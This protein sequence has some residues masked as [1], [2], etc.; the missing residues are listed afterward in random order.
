MLLHLLKAK[1]FTVT[2]HKDIPSLI[3]DLDRLLAHADSPLPWSTPSEVASARSVLEEVRHYL[4]ERQHGEVEA[5]VRPNTEQSIARSAEQ[6]LNRLR[7]EWVDTLQADLVGLHQQRES[8]VRDIRQLESKRQHLTQPR[9]PLSQENAESSLTQI[10]AQLDVRLGRIESSVRGEG[11][12]SGRQ[13]T[14]RS[15][16]LDRLQ[17]RSDRQIVAL[18]ASQ[19]T[20]FATLQ[21]NLR[22]YEQS[23]SQGLERMHHLGV[24]GE[25]LVA[26]LV[27]RITQQLEQASV[28]SPEKEADTDAQPSPAGDEPT[29]TE[30]PTPS[31]EPALEVPDAD[32]EL[33]DGLDWDDSDFELDEDDGLDTFIQLDVGAP[34]ALP[35]VEEIEA[36][37]QSN[38]MLTQAESEATATQSEDFEGHHPE[39]QALYESLFG[40][41]ALSGTPVRDDAE[42]GSDRQPETFATHF[43]LEDDWSEAV[44]AE[45]PESESPE[46]LTQDEGNASASTS[47]LEASLFSGLSDPATE[48]METTQTPP[49]E[50]AQSWE[51]FLFEDPVTPPPA[52]TQRTPQGSHPLSTQNGVREREG[53]ETISAL[54]A[55]F[56]EMGLSEEVAAT[57]TGES[58]LQAEDVP[59][60]ESREDWSEDAYIYASPGEDLLAT[61]RLESVPEIDIS[62][63]PDSLQNLREDLHSFEETQAQ[64]SDRLQDT[65]EADA[66]ETPGDEPHLPELESEEFLAEDWEEFTSEERTE[67][68]A[69]LRSL[70]DESEASDFD[71]DLFPPEALE[72]HQEQETTTS[73][74]SQEFFVFEEQTLSEMQWD[75]T[76]GSV[77]EETS[78]A[79]EQ[80]QD[81]SEEQSSERSDE[82]E[83]LH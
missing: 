68:D 30:E 11:V 21:R 36:V 75:E 82:E 53:V 13:E 27:E 44:E 56:E 64:E 49:R 52:R 72:L 4:S 48:T 9:L 28:S 77:P 83:N 2:A 37:G 80:P 14:P 33:L 74:D 76:F 6:E 1:G 81:A 18:D 8:L 70:A 10:L 59:E 54:T 78:T 45:P 25:M 15:E 71:P 62:L 35:S 3:H 69:K 60:T 5:S 19:Q 50:F 67:E 65:T 47:R 41:D 34:A 73:A 7:A 29:T 61:D 12:E 66:S 58:E 79:P 16:P 55:L 31:P 43:S 24:Q 38:G 40:R 63:E 22:S 46:P 17:A 20:I 51:A 39:L 26:A 57:E 42:N 23:L 32:W